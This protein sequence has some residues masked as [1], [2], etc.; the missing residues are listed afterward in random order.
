M[1]FLYRLFR[2]D[3]DSREGIIL[4]TSGLGIITNV[5][6]AAVKV[7]IGL[8]ASSIAIISE[9]VNN[10]SDALTSV[11]TL[12][13]TKLAGKHP[14]AKH[15]FGYGRIEYLTSLIVAV[16]ILVTGIETL[17]SSVERIFQ[18]ADLAVSYLSLAI[19][20]FSAVVKFLLGTYTVKMGKKAGSGAL[21]AVGI[22]SRNDSLISVVTIAASL[23]FL[24]SGVSLDAY[25][26]IFISVLILKA[27]FEVLKDTVSDLLGKP[28]ES[29]LASDLYR[30]IRSTK[31]VIGA[32]DMM[33]HNYGPDAYTGSCNL[34]IDHETTVGEIYQILRKLQIDIYAKYKVAMIFGLYAVDNDHEGVR[35]LRRDIASFV[36]NYEHVKS[37]HAVYLEPE[38]DR[39]YCDFIVDYDLQD[40]DAL[41]AE[42]NA[43]MAERYPA[44]E[45]A[46]NI[47]T[48]FV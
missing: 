27:G 11:L 38:T 26:G 44:S 7:V 6:I 36:R 14:D 8:L 4:T 46:L 15:P 1:R 18:P 34:E 45:I 9:G 29:E 24:L 16:F 37:F 33:L 42:F 10:A 48:E 43:Y 22:D 3:P 31:G 13:G 5:F 21:E 40:W 47:E 12:V 19:I 2:Q 35:E 23:V 30:E 32:V 41:R 39:I 20:A 28:A 25:A 17:K